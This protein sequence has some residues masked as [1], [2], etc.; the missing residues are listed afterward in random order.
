[1]A[2]VCADC[3]A[4]FHFPLGGD[5]MIETSE[6][7][8]VARSL[9]GTPYSE[10]D[11]IN[12]IKKIIRVAKGGDPKYTDAGTASLWASYNS[13]GKYRHLTWRQD[14]IYGAEAGMLAFKGKPLGTDGQPH[15][16]GLVTSQ[17]TV[18]HSSSEKG[19]VVETPLNKQWTLLGKSRWIEISVQKEEPKPEPEKGDDAMVDLPCT[20]KVYAP[21]GKTVNLRSEPN[22][23]RSNVIDRIP[24]G[25]IVTVTAYVGDGWAFISADGKVGYMMTKFL[26]KA[27]PHE[28]P[29]EPEKEP[30]EIPE[31]Y[32]VYGLWLPV[33]TK[34]DAESFASLFARAEVEF[35]ESRD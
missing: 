7:I 33:G 21:K 16:V 27:D 24:I 13:S 35:R 3:H 25:T 23:S 32:R 11:C 1:M 6:A 10:L 22:D 12:L 34:E 14:S 2:C 30:E 15:H 9:L 19:C 26:T 5:E 17:T 18:I 31:K 28:E 8:R 4:A 29:E 20:A